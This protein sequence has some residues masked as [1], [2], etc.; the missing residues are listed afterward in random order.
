[1]NNQPNEFC[2]EKHHKIN[3]NDNKKVF[4]PDF[5]TIPWLTNHKPITQFMQVEAPV[6]RIHFSIP[7]YNLYSNPPNI[8]LNVNYHT[9]SDTE[10]VPKSYEGVPE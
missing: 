10:K 7:P 6:P 3:L 4:E 9:S 1:M 8:P 2:D 5:S